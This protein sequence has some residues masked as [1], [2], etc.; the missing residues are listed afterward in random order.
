M[1]KPTPDIQKI[2]ELWETWEKGKAEPG[3]LMSQLKMYGLPEILQQLVE[4]T[5]NDENTKTTR[6]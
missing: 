1:K 3:K 2:Q 5:E 4:H 6:E